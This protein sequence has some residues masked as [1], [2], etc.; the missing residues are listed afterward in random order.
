MNAQIAQKPGRFDGRAMLQV[1]L[2][3]A[4]VTLYIL[5]TGKLPFPGHSDDDILK[6]HQLPIHYPAAMSAKLRTLLQV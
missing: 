1:D 3:A 4:A 6:A 5:A 2:W